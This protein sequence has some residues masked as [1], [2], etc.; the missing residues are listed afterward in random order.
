MRITDLLKPKAIEIGAKVKDKEAKKEISD[1]MTG[2][3][4]TA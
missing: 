2:A 3:C 4:F 1:A